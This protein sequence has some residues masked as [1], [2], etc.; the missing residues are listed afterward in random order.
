MLDTTD[1]N[2]DGR[3]ENAECVQDDF[4]A[5][6]INRNSQGTCVHSS[7]L[8][9]M[10]GYAL[11]GACRAAVYTSPTTTSTTSTSTSTSTSTGTATTTPTA[12]TATTPTTTT[13][14]S[15]TTAT[16]ST[17][18]APVNDGASASGGRGG[19]AIAG[20]VIGALCVAGLVIGAA[21][22]AMVWRKH[23]QEGYQRREQA[24]QELAGENAFEMIENPMATAGSPTYT[25]TSSTGST[26]SITNQ[27]LPVYENSALSPRMSQ[28]NDRHQAAAEYSEPDGNAEV[29][30]LPAGAGAQQA[31]TYSAPD[32]SNAMLYSAAAGGNA[33]DGDAGMNQAPGQSAA[34]APVYENVVHGATSSSASRGS[35]YENVDRASRGGGTRLATSSA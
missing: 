15:P 29:Y 7:G 6:G 16:T 28:H 32:E 1:K 17:T 22:Y 10:D 31:A 9:I 23:Q 4:L 26:P 3:I 14:T 5:S 35:V 18:S 13:V 8:R 30:A 34:P 21:Y 25:N 33:A 27:Q 2:T 11:G 20:Q 19:G 24:V 12:T